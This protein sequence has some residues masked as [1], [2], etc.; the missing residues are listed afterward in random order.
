M[1]S[2][3]VSPGLQKYD[4]FGGYSANGLLKPCSSAYLSP[5]YPIM[6][7]YDTLKVASVVLLLSGCSKEKNEESNTSSYPLKYPVTAGF[8]DETSGIADSRRNAGN[9]WVI[10]DSRRP[11][12]LSLLSHKGVA[13]GKVHIKGINNRDWE[14]MFLGKGPNASLDYIY[15][16]DLGDNYFI[17]SEYFI[18]RLPEPAAGTDTVFNAETIRFRYSDGPHD[19]EAMLQDGATGNIYIITKQEAQ[20]GIYELVY[21]QSTTELNTAEPVGKLPFT[22]VVSA[23]TQPDQGGLV[24]KTY[25][26]IHYYARQAGETVTAA[27]AR[28]SQLLP[29]E[30]EPQGEAVSFSLDGKG[31]FTLSEKGLG[32]IRLY[33]YLK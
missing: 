8:V 12:E 19:A 3:P 1:L 14:D 33:Y 24:V 30:I 21:P 2:K 7:L 15:I 22:S 18:Y 28:P 6:T 13:S 17:R 10:Q 5:I 4:V 27:L 26:N 25:T 9:L 20:A 32:E 16:G 31:Y 11:P 23:A 29:Y